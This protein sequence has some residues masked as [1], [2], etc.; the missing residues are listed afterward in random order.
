M[1]RSITVIKTKNMNNKIDII[2]IDG[3]NKGEYSL[4]YI[5]YLFYLASELD[6]NGYSFKILNIR[7]L[8]KFTLCSIIE[9]LKKHNFSS[10]GITTNAENIAN[11]YKVCKIIK[12]YFSN[13][14][15]ILGGPQVTF[16]DIKTL[17]ECDCDIVVRN[18][19]EKSLIQILDCII[20][21][22]I[23]LEEIKGITFKKENEII[24]NKDD[25]LLNINDFGTPVYGLLSEE[26]YWIIPDNGYYKDFKVF[27]D[28]IS[29]K[30]AFFLTGR[31][32]PYRCAFCVEG[33]SNNK[34]RFRSIEKV[35]K[36]LKCFLS[37]TKTKYL[38]FADDTFTSSVKRVSELCKMIKEVQEEVYDFRWFAEGRVDILSKHPE[39]INIMHNAGLRKLQLGLE[40]GRQETLDVYNKGIT[41]EQI[42]KVILVASKYKDLAIHGNIMMANPKESFDEYLVTIEFFKKLSLLSNF[43]LDIGVVY[44]APFVGTPIRLNPEKYEMDM[45][46]E[47]FEFKSLPM[48]NIVCKSKKMTLNEVYAMRTY[49]YHQIMGFYRNELFKLSKDEILSLFNNLKD[50]TSGI[51]IV[52]VLKQLSSF[53][54]FFTISMAKA[55]INEIS[56]KSIDYCPLRLWE[57][58]YNEDNGYS[59]TSLKKEKFFL[60]EKDKL[61]WE[62]AS[63]KNTLY[64][65]H[66]IIN[67]FSNNAVPFDYILSFY[68]ELDNNFA[69]VFRKY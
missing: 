36:D 17:K 11:V 43:N 12:L 23:K 18:M 65:I 45:L 67:S 39:M 62:L 28:K 32:C 46:I 25:N 1:Y 10:I 55:T 27:L 7:S 64:E 69:I 6:S 29:K 19:G 56:E 51:V 37:V 20:E 68:K 66:E 21:E 33:N 8:A 63:G 44:L 50:T 42:E 24:R 53:K 38:V 31:G 59:F 15:I 54:R 2:F 40:T 16:S 30:Y 34:F 14:P 5:G 35:K 26:K 4:S 57:L 22:K 13:I 3:L 9:E 61:L 47:D 48:S 60:K 52:G 41:L 49:T 58:E